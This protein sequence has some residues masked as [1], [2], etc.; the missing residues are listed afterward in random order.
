MKLDEVMALSNEDLRI[1]A[2][3]L[4]GWLPPES[5]DP[6]PNGMRFVMPAFG[7]DVFYELEIAG[8]MKSFPAKD[9]QRAYLWHTE[10]GRAGNKPP[11]YLNDIAAAMKLAESLPRMWSF[12]RLPDASA[13]EVQF[14]DQVPIESIENKSL[15]H[16]ITCFYVF[17]RTQEEGQHAKSSS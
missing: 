14:I 16:G 15:A 3:E 7:E 11:D 10:D 8:Q 2:A 12:T 5:E 13:W 9:I 4:D 6:M 17:A 1:K